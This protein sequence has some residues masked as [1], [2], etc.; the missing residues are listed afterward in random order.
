MR[1]LRNAGFTLLELLV[2]MAIFA[3][4][5]VVMYSGVELVMDEREIVLERLGELEDLQRA[6]RHLQSDFSQL[7]PRQV[8]DVLGRSSVGALQTEDSGEFV[9][10]LTR[11]GWRNPANAKRS[12]LQRVQY[13]YDEDARVLYREYWPV[14]DAVLGTEPAS[15]ALLEGVNEFEV[16]FLDAASNWQQEWPP[17]DAENL[18]SLPRAV[19][20]RLSLDSYGEITRI[21]EVPG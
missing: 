6:V 18:T 2:S 14:L 11:G 10:Q 4:L 15:R 19:R 12:H 9:L 20:Y 17:A 7:Y 8:R 13:R 16:E 1:V 5:A 3:I 21:V